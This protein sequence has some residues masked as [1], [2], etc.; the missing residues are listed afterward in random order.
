MVTLD[1]GASSDPDGD[2]LVYAWA[3]YTEPSSYKGSVSI[4]GSPSSSATVSVP[5]DAGGKTIHV[6]LTLRDNGSPNLYA[7]R[8]VILEVQE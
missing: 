4:Q 3:V 1:G 5:S 2:S 8:R 6:I 7:Y